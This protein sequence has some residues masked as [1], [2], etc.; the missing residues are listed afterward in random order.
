M[1]CKTEMEIQYPPAEVMWVWVHLLYS[2]YSIAKEFMGS[3]HC[4]TIC[5]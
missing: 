3:F 4:G 5:D 1:A 2:V